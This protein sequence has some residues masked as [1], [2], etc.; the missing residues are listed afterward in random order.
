MYPHDFTSALV[1]VH[2]CDTFTAS[3][4][5]LWIGACIPTN[6]VLY[7]LQHVIMKPSQHEC[8]SDGFE[9]HLHEFSSASATAPH[10]THPH[11]FSSDQSEEQHKDK[12]ES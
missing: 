12:F 4:E 11:E 2:H 8:D 5:F 3:I 1:D 7:R 10:E 9:I 6:S